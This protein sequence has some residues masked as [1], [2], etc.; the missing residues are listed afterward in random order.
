MLKN[1]PTT[2]HQLED[3]HISV[4]PNHEVDIIW[5]FIDFNISGFVPY[6]Q[7]VGDSNK[8]NRISEF[9]IHY[10]QFCISEQTGG[11]LPYYFA[12][13]PTQSQSGSET[14]IGIYATISNAKP[15][16]LIEFEAKR[17]SKESNNK[18]YVC[19]KR[20]GIERFKRG[21]HAPRLSACGMFAYVQSNKT[22]YWINKINSWIHELSNANIQTIH[23]SD[24]EVLHKVCSYYQVEKFSSIHQ[25]LSND[26][27]ALWHYFI[28]L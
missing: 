5:A 1:N 21:V 3:G 16:T 9:L 2:Y 12:K 20:G 13:N 11:Y 24:E 18:E 26:S 10:F 15:V 4:A 7:S 25:R 22:E 19:G 8:E 23:W 28:E 6:Y 17:L 14:D 27:I